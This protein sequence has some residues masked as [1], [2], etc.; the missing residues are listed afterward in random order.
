M[1]VA[2]VRSG[3]RAA[4]WRGAVVCLLVPASGSPRVTS[5]DDIGLRSGFQDYFGGHFKRGRSLIA[6]DFD[7]DGRIDAFLGNPGDESLVLRNVGTVGKPRFVVAQVLMTGGLPYGGASADYDNDGDYDLFISGGG[8]EGI[9]QDSLFR[10]R[11]V[12]DGAL[13][14]EDVTDAAGIRGPVPPGETEWVATASANAVWGDYDQDGDVDLF[15]SSQDSESPVLGKRNILW[16]NQGDGTFVDATE[17]AGLAGSNAASQH[18]TFFDFDNDG[19]LDLYEN[20]RFEP[21]VLWRNLSVESGAASFEDVTALLSP[22]GEDLSY[23]SDSFVSCAADFDNDGWE[24]LFVTKRTGQPEPPESPYGVGHALFMNQGGNGFVNRATSSG[25]ND[26]FVGAMGFQIGDVTADG[27]PDIYMGKGLAFSG[28]VDR[29]YLS[30]GMTFEGAPT[31]DNRTELIDFPVPEDPER[32]YPPY[33]YRSHGTAFVA[34]TQDG[35]LEIAV[36]SGGPEFVGEDAR[37][38]NRLFRLSVGTTNYLR[39]RPVG[40]GASVSRDGVGTRFTLEVSNSITGRRH[41]LRRTLY[42]GQCFSAQNGFYVHFLLGKADT[43]EQLRVTW[44]NGQSEVI[45]EALTV[46]TS[47][48]VEQGGVVLA[49]AGA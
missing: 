49:G 31:Y 35:L 39:I 21:N 12:E 30:T 44:P 43:V 18:S 15:V 8:I 7:L 23:P 37:D 20:N 28:V 17:A 26:Q 47:I 16:Q 24:D 40:D 36:N 32:E 29:L 41:T 4:L 6:A 34:F 10:N 33:P 48:V 9:D 1:R 45:T 11:L 46:N 42:A 38:P 25:L 13:R 22:P 5:V 3:A 2:A 14:F 27:F 19:D